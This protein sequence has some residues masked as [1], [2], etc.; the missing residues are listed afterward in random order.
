MKDLTVLAPQND[1][2]RVDTPAD[3][4]DGAGLAT[5]ARE[6]G[7]G[8]RKIHLR[9]L[10]YM[11]IDADDFDLPVPVVP[12]SELNGHHA[13]APLLDLGWSFADQRRRL[14]ASKAYRNLGGPA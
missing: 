12:T 6:L 13:G 8:D 10:H 2:F 1:P 3:H 4:R 5:T 14:I 7:L 9:G 11:R